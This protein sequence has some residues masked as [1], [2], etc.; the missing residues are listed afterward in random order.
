MRFFETNF[1]CCKRAVSQI[2]L[3]LSRLVGDAI[4]QSRGK[5]LAWTHHNSLSYG[6]FSEVN[7]SKLTKNAFSSRRISATAK[8]TVS[9]IWLK[10]S[11][12]VGHAIGQS[13]G[14]I[15]RGSAIIH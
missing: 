14:K 7:S 10:Q 13:P 11:T 5:K 1:S 3:K 12:L 2:L 15:W 6:H 8:K 4:G 9:Q